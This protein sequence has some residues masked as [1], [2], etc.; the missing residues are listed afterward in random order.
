MFNAKRDEERIQNLIQKKIKGTNHFT[1]LVVD[2]RVILQWIL[3]DVGV[4]GSGL[5]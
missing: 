1:D 4:S 3:E 2:D 5:D